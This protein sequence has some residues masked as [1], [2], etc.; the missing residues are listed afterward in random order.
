MEKIKFVDLQKSAKSIEGNIKGK[1]NNLLFNDC[2]YVNG[3]QVKHFETNF[4]NYIG[5]KYCAS[6]NS[7]AD[8]IKF[9][10]KFLNVTEADEILVQGN[11]F[12]GS[13]S[14]ASEL[15][16]NIKILDVDPN[17]YMIDLNNIEKNINKNTKAII[18][19]HLFGLC[20]DMDE[21]MRIAKKHNLF[22]IEDA[23]QAHGGCYK[24]KKLGSIGD[25]GC[26]SF[27]PSKN[28]GAMGDGGCITTNNFELYNN[29]KMWSNC[30]QN[31]KYHHKFTGCN[32]RL[33]TL[34]AIILDEKLKYLDINNRK[35]ITHATTYNKLLKQQAHVILPQ[36]HNSCCPVWH[37]YVIRVQNKE[38]RD[39][40]L[41]H[42]NS[43]GIECGIHYPVPIHMLDA[44][45]ELRTQGTE[46]KNCSFLADRI[47]SLPM[48]P[49]LN[50]QEII[51]VVEKINIFFDKSNKNP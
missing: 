45:P 15:G 5:T 16:C 31:K 43:N 33:D 32:S 20:C 22:V 37:L 7:G 49:E 13:I 9:S 36:Y 28:L 48:Y 23:A 12:I 50:K 39:N 18:I 40:L 8:A 2:H 38:I 27:Y 42:L 46:L 19:V 26:F 10:L 35:R 51:Q 41:K 29:I 11:T 6:V 17:T 47:L 4:S 24:N 1:I 14:G 21:I 25:V 3:E 30:G 34:Q 44:Y